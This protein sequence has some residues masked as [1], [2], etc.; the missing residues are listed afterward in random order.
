[1][2]EREQRRKAQLARNEAM[3]R[4]VNERLREL[5]ESFAMVSE[6]ASF[7]C[8][9]ADGECAEPIELSL[10]DYERVRSNPRHFVVVDGH[11]R[12]DIEFV[13][14]ELPPYLV[15]EKHDGALEEIVVATDPRR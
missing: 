7:V 15:V 5:G 6:R 11:V 12:P 4:E 13:A 1:M 10:P 9:C 3:F 8:E 14:Y 2:S